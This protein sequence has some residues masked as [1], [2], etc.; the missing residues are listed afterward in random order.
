MEWVC[1]LKVYDRWKIYIFPA[2][3][4]VGFQASQECFFVTRVEIFL[5]ELGLFAVEFTVWTWSV[6]NTLLWTFHH[7]ELTFYCTLFYVFMHLLYFLING[8]NSCLCFCLVYCRTASNQLFIFS[9]TDF[10]FDMSLKATPTCPVLVVE[11]R[12]LAAG[13]GCS[14]VQFSFSKV[15]RGSVEQHELQAMHNEGCTYLPYRY[16]YWLWGYVCTL[17]TFYAFYAHCNKTNLSPMWSGHVCIF[18]KAE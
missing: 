8:V 4:G 17:W 11:I 15:M 9:H 3:C 6:D 18:H 16:F 10:R 13:E 1:T 5:P 14:R 7:R 12:R 2:C